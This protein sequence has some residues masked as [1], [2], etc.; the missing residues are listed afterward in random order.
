MA[1]DTIA[2]Y[3][4]EEIRLRLPELQKKYN[5]ETNSMAV[6]KAVEKVLTPPQ[7]PALVKICLDN[8]DSQIYD[9][10]SKHYGRSNVN[11]SLRVVV[12]EQLRKL[13]QLFQLEQSRVVTPRATLMR[14]RFNPQ[15][16]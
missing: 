12:E 5:V 3:L 8:I 4:P 10:L 11:C 9:L 7:V 1:D 13:Y 2:T 16:K 15:P 14:E 6:R